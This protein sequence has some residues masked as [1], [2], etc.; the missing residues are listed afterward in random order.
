MKPQEFYR[1]LERNKIRPFYYFYGPE[2]GLISEAIHRIGEKILNPLTREFNREIINAEGESS[3]SVLEK[4]HTLP[5]RSAWRLLIIRQAD[6][7]WKKDAAVLI[8]YLENPNPSTCAIFTGEKA[9][10]RLKF[11]QMLEKKG[12]VVAFYSPSADEI[13]GWMLTAAR[14]FG[15]SLSEEAGVLLLERIGPSLQD[16]KGEIQK[17]AASLQ[18]GQEINLAEVEKLT[19]D[20]RRESPFELPKAIGRLDF[21]DALSLFQKNRQQGDSPTLLLSL[22]LRHLRN[23]Y[24]A[25]EMRKKGVSD[26]EIEKD[27]RI[28]PRQANDFWEQ[29]RRIPAHFWEEAWKVSMQVDRMLKS[30]RGEKELLFEEYLWRLSALAERKGLKGGRA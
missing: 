14:Q 4:L 11:F 1:E 18:E 16:L 7:A 26:R 20:N 17:I 6:V 21:K 8:S 19:E 3:S 22:V 24:R 5:L 23:L 13:F 12:A 10:L 15:H 27:L 28:L 29:V 30:S 9:D 2:R 25:Q